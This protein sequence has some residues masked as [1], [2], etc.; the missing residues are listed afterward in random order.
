M[1][2][3]VGTSGW[4]YP[5]WRPDVYPAGMPARGFL[6]HHA[7]LFGMCEV[8]ATF[9]RMPSAATTAA[10]ADQTPPGY[11]LVAKLPRAVTYHRAGAGVPDPAT[12]GR[13][14]DGLAPL[15]ARTRAVLVQIA[16]TARRDDGLL[17]GFLD[18]LTPA[19]AP[20][21]DLGHPSWA[22]ADVADRVA[23]AGGTVC[24]T[25]TGG[26]P[27]PRLPP[28]PLAYVRLRAEAY[29]D[30]GREAW[31]ALLAE[32]GAARPVYAVAR[33]KDLPADDAHCGVGLGLWLCHR[34]RDAAPG[35]PAPPPAAGSPPEPA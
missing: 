1:S 23:A 22:S 15:T 6:A 29:D 28:G 26:P 4:S 12:V 13:L 30:A 16:P 35:R 3:R 7:T 24:V 32:E 19:F 20:V 11:H 9:Y 21:M 8:N 17:A 2:V 25:H 14:V 5:E 27:A 33:H 10:W 34:L 31:A 18:A